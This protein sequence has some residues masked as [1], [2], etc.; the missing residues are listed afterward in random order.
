MLVAPNGLAV[1]TDDVCT[2]RTGRDPL[3]NETGGRGTE[4]FRRA[5]EDNDNEEEVEVEVAEENEE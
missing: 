5:D 2:R 1:C 3:G 4:P